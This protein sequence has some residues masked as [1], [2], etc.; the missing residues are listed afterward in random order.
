MVLRVCYGGK[1]EFFMRLI[2]NALFLTF[3]TSALACTPKIGDDCLLG[4][5]CSSKGDRVCDTSLPGGY[6]TVLSCNTDSCPDDG[7]CVLFQSSVPGCIYND[8]AT[9]R[10]A[11]TYCM[12]F[13]EDDSDCRDGYVCLDPKAE[14]LRA[15]IL[16]SNQGKKVC[17]VRP[18]AATI[19][20]SS[21]EP[22][23]LPGT[24]S[25]Q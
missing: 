9:S 20:P 12:A 3:M 22:V 2:L 16:D 13:C 4:A 7:V 11:R 17:T 1:S 23:C 21:Q 15:S 8:R 5:D 18:T 6:C 25:S 14:P 10:T 19:N 24:P